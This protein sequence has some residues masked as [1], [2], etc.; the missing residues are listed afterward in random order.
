MRLESAFGM[1]TSSIKYGPGVTREV[2][3]DMSRLGA[4]PGHG[5]DR[6]VCRRSRN[7]GLGAR[8]APVCGDRTGIL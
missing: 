3:H 8:S 7:D 1:D 4:Q 6:P 2:G 5:C